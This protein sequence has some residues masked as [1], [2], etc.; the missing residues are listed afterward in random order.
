M[1]FSESHGRVLL[2]TLYRGGGE[3]STPSKASVSWRTTAWTTKRPLTLRCLKSSAGKIDLCSESILR[4]RQRQHRQRLRQRN[5]SQHLHHS[6]N[7]TAAPP[8]GTFAEDHG[9]L[10]AD[11]F[12][13]LVKG[14]QSGAE[15]RRP[16]RF[17]TRT[18]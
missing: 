12:V 16:V 17:R 10:F 6:C 15:R 3:E 7:S 2:F 1:F 5:T 11:F 14:F 4:L 8:G 13:G 9:Q 18:Q